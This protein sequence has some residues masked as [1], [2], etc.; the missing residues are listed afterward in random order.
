MAKFDKMVERFKTLNDIKDIDIAI[1]SLKNIESALKEAISHY[2]DQEKLHSP[3]E[4]WYSN[5]RDAYERKLDKVDAVVLGLI[6]KK[7]SLA[8]QEVK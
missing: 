7:L 5:A 6:S 1:D 4:V 2:E 3:K 8:P